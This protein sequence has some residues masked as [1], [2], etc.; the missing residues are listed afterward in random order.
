MIIAFLFN[1]YTR[2][3]YEVKTTVL[4]E[5]Q[6]GGD[7]DPQSLIGL[8]FRNQWQSLE[9]EM[10]KLLSYSLAERTIKSL[11]FEVSYFIEENFITQELYKESPVLVVFDTSH[12]Y[13][14]YVEF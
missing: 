5:N 3:I 12:R 1:K 9:N 8:G 11:D 2:P 13:P 7:I 4:I 10:G 14:I 6:R